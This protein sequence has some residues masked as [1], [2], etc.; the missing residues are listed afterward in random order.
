MTERV[1]SRQKGNGE[2]E[3]VV[4]GCERPFPYPEV[5]VGRE[6]VKGNHMPGDFD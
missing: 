3:G 6:R 2:E 1:D 5:M 4:G